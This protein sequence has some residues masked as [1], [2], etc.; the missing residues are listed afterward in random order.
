MR[1]KSDLWNFILH[2]FLFVHAYSPFPQLFCFSFFFFMC[3]L[4]LIWKLISI[5]TIYQYLIADLK[6]NGFD[7]CW[8]LFFIDAM[9]WTKELHLFMAALIVWFLNNVVKTKFK[10]LEFPKCSINFCLHFNNQFPIGFDDL[11]K[12]VVGI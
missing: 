2:F 6:W 1:R 4:N 12:H 10:Q 8:I 3:V 7:S 9:C 5:Q 11:H